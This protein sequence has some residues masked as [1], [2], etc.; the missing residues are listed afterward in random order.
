MS[1]KQKR[2]L[3]R[4]LKAA[5]VGLLSLIALWFVIAVVL[6]ALLFMIFGGD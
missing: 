1:R 2:L 3:L 5:A 4:A 6:V